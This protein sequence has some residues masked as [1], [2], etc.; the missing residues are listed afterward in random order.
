LAGVLVVEGNIVT[1]IG[2]DGLEHRGPIR[3][4]RRAIVAN[5]VGGLRRQAR[6][7][8]GSG[9]ECQRDQA[10]VHVFVL[11]SSNSP[12]VYRPGVSLL[13]QATADAP[14]PVIRNF[15]IRQFE[16]SV[17]R[18]LPIRQQCSPCRHWAYICDGGQ[19]PSR[20]RVMMTMIAT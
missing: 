15:P 19:M 18:A 5:H 16:R 14:S 4:L 1:E 11:P 10:L 12:P 2:L 3:P 17:A 7:S 6:G 9:G 20:K 8:R 13:R